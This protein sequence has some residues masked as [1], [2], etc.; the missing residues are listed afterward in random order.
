MSRVALPTREAGEFLIG[1]E[2]ELAGTISS[3]PISPLAAARIRS[4]PPS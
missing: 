3:P 4:R 1:I 2:D